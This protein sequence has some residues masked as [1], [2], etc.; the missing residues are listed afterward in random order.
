MSYSL[1]F[2]LL[3][4]GNEPGMFDLVIVNDDLE[5]AYDKLKSA[6]MEVSLC[7]NEIVFKLSATVHLLKKCFFR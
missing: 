2:T 7:L 5:A 1:F 6:L 3:L 4:L